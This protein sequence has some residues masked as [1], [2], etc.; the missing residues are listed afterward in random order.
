MNAVILHFHS[1]KNYRIPLRVCTF[2][3]KKLK[4]KMRLL[5]YNKNNA[6]NFLILPVCIARNMLLYLHWSVSD[7]YTRVRSA[8]RQSMRMFSYIPLPIRLFRVC[9]SQA[10]Q[11]I[12]TSQRSCLYMVHMR[13]KSDYK[14]IRLQIIRNFDLLPTFLYHI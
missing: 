11:V 9:T 14:Y 6:N 7:I 5:G 4:S 3:K 2:M 12:L 13:L 1:T 8:M 10:F